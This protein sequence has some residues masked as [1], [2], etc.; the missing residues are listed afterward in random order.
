VLNFEYV[1]QIARDWNT[2]DPV[3]GYA[4]WVTRFEVKDDYAQ[5]FEPQTVGAAM[6]RE[7]C[8]C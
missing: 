4:G 7:L 2:R 5:Q 6:H 8:S 3:S 1:A